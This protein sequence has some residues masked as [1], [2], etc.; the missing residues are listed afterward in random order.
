MYSF[1][2]VLYYLINLQSVVVLLQ[3]SGTL[4]ILMCLHTDLYDLPI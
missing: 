4:D 1:S 3:D 2:S